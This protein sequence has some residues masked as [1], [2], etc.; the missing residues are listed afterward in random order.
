MSNFI[1]S[2]FLFSFLVLFISG[3]SAFEDNFNDG[4]LDGWN[5][6]SGSWDAYGSINGNGVMEHSYS[7][8]IQYFKIKLRG[9]LISGGSYCSG[10]YDSLKFNFA[11]NSTSSHYIEFWQGGTNY[12]AC[13]QGSPTPGRFIKTDLS[14]YTSS[15]QWEGNQNYTIIGEIS[16]NNLLISVF[17]NSNVL[18]DSD[19]ISYVPLES[20][21]TSLENHNANYITYF[22]D[23]IVSSINVNLPTFVDIENENYAINDIIKASYSVSNS[24][25]S[26]LYSYKLNF[27]NAANEK[28]LYSYSDLPQSGTYYIQPTNAGSLRVDLIKTFLGDTVLASDTALVGSYTSYIFMNNV[29]AVGV[30]QNVSYRWGFTP[31]Q[32]SYKYITTKWFDPKTNAWEAEYS[33]I[34]TG[35]TLNTLYTTQI[36]FAKEGLYLVE[37]K[38]LNKQAVAASVQVNAYL[39]GGIPLHNFTR[40]NLTVLYPQVQYA[41]GDWL[42][43]S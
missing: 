18:M 43:Y 37:L 28:I 16:G 6:I 35:T 2:L 23:I 14:G 7:G 31:T 27:V 41:A 20:T 29:A 13:G 12:V 36:L 4:N 39:Q 25:W 32:N 1:R 10:A 8:S 5:I 21:K 40:S 33:Y 30:L 26:F 19:Y 15:F 17:N 38:D 9:S 3:A 34:V 11:S 24:F 22:D 42:Q